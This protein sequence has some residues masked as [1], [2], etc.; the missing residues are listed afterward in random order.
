MNKFLSIVLTL[1]SWFSFAQ[2]NNQTILVKMQPATYKQVVLYASEGAQQKYITHGESETG[3]FQL[4]IPT[5]APHASYR[6]VYNQ[7]TMDYI[8]FLYLGKS[9]EIQFNPTNPNELPVF[10]NSEENTHYFK[11]LFTVN[12]IQQKMDSIQVEIFKTDNSQTL[13]ALQNQYAI[14][15]NELIKWVSLIEKTETNPLIKDILKAHDRVLPQVPIQDPLEYLNFIKLH[16]FDHIDF[17]NSN[18][19]HSSILLDKVMD[20]VF[21][22]TV[23][24]TPESQNTL[25]IG[26]IQEVMQKIQNET[27][28]P[29]FI[30]AL[31]QSF[32]QDENAE[33]ID[34][35]FEKYYNLLP[36]DQQN[37][38]WKNGIQ[39]QLKTAIGRTAPDFE[40]IFNKNVS[41]LYKLSGYK[42]YV[43][44][45]WSTSCSHCLK[46]IPM[47]YDYIKDR[48][49]TKV[50]AIGMESYD[51]KPN[52]E[53]EIYDYPAFIN[54]MGLGK[55]ENSIARDYNIHATPNYFIL[56]T[57]K[58][59][60]FKPYDFE[61]AE[62]IFDNLK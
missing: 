10:V 37:T 48:P 51:S 11:Q 46:E 16:F 8:D 55:W 4:S 40:F 1:V 24:E 20:Y 50:I 41:S 54:V 12:S 23:A 15:Q 42:Y 21:Y 57:S 32:L 2:T 19:I 62:E 27:I 22:L 58:K 31:I 29:G 3:F 28:K 53:S 7:E 60:I 35:L 33:V 44:V 59:I 43:I 17:D 49:D 56:D 52:W 39:N 61:E 13:S 36:A 9:F 38:N 47:F 26:A 25:Y 18:M 34:V 14:Q 45:F 6:M 5:D 30:Q